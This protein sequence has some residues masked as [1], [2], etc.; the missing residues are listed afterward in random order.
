METY[1][2]NVRV[3]GRWYERYEIEAESEEDARD[4]YIDGDFVGAYE[5]CGNEREV[6]EVENWGA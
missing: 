4:Q 2:V 1:F 6:E 5:H 3:V